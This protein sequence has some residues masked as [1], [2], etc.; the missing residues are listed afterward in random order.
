MKT[1]LIKL[2]IGFTSMAALSNCIYAQ[3]SVGPVAF[4][5][6][7]T[8]KSSIR[9]LT[10]LEN[11]TSTGSYIP[12]AKDIQSKAVKDFQ[13]RFSNVSNAVWFSDPNGFLSY[14]VQDGYGNRVFYD[15]KG[16][17]KFSLI[18]YGENKLPRDIR[19][20]IKSTYY[21]LAITLVK[22]VRTIDGVGYVVNL[23]D[24]SNIKIIKINNGGEMEILLELT[25]E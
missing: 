4:S 14:F 1:T 8:F 5:S 22:E 20:L 7:K 15:K 16:R 17:W 9:S 13:I 12:D 11:L 3:N 19:A 6:T 21:D 23:E 18:L 2:S 25:K 24:K 10:A